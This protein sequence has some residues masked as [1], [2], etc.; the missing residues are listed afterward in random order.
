MTYVFAGKRRGQEGA[1]EYVTEGSAFTELPFSDYD[2]ST[3][4]VLKGQGER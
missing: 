3:G 2:Q 4:Y 1:C